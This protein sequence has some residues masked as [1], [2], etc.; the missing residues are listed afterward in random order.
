VAYAFEHIVRLLA[1]LE[2]S[3]TSLLLNVKDLVVYVIL[4]ENLFGITDLKYH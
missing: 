4:H 1:L 2:D 3:L